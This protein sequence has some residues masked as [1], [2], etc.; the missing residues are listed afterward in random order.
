VYLKLRGKCEQRL[1]N[2]KKITQYLNRLTAG[3]TN[4]G[5]IQTDYA[6]KLEEQFDIFTYKTS[7]IKGHVN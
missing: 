3:T 5:K 7:K 2:T 6:G 4:L 1:E